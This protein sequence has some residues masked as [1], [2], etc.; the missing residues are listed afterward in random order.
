MHFNVS[1][2]SSWCELVQLIEDQI[3]IQIHPNQF[4][5][6]ANLQQT[7]LKTYIQ[8]RKQSQ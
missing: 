3:Q 5:H 6:T 1:E 2:G 7:T 4:P 8:K